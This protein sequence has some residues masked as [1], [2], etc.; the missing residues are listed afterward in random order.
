LLSLSWL[1][2]LELLLEFVNLSNMLSD[3]ILWNDSLSVDDSVLDVFLDGLSIFVVDWSSSPLLD[4]DE[5]LSVLANSLLDDDL[6]GWFLDDD[7]SQSLDFLGNL[8]L[9]FLT[10]LDDLGLDNLLI[11]SLSLSLVSSL[12]L[13]LPS[14]DLVGPFSHDNLVDDSIGDN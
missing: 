6:L 5:S 4:E 12:L 13:S 7:L 3:N 1:S 8:L 10:M 11:E 9:V 2:L 14:D